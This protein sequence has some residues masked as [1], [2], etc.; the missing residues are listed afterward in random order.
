LY[1]MFSTSKWREVR[2]L[3]FGKKGSRA[4]T[5][6]WDGDGAADAAIEFQ[7]VWWRVTRDLDVLPVPA[8]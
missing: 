1:R 8:P 6:D 4:A 3:P 2:T 7:G 5:G